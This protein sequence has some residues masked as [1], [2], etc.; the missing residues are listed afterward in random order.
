M[1]LF[2]LTHWHG[3]NSKTVSYRYDNVVATFCDICQFIVEYIRE[4]HDACVILSN[5][6]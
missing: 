6:F 1:L 5:Y 4:R 2:P 3:D